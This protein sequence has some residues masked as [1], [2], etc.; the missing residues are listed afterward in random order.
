MMGT[1]GEDTCEATII[2]P[3]EGIE[4]MG[5]TVV[6]D[7]RSEA[8]GGMKGRDTPTACMDASME[9]IVAMAEMQSKQHT[10]YSK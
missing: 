10:V 1:E 5:D 4:G 7:E 3:K 2:G 9:E 6:V 8:K